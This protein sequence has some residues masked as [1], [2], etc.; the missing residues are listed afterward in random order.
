MK[1]NRIEAFHKML[2]WITIISFS[3]AWGVA[4]AFAEDGATLTGLSISGANSLNEST[5]SSYR[6]V[7]RFSDG[8]TRTVTSNA[9][10]SENSSF[11]TISGGVLQAGSVGSNQTVTITAKYV[12]GGV[13]RTAN[14][15]VTIV[16]VASAASLTGVAVTGPSSVNEGATSNYTATAT[17]S[18]GTTTNV[19]S[20][21]TWSENSTAAT[22]STSGAL[23][24]AQVTANQTVTV[25]ASYTSGTVTR[26]GNLNV[27]IVDSVPANTSKSINSTS[28]NRSTLPAGPVAEQALTTLTNFNI[29][30]VND[31]GMHCG[32]LDHRI[33]SILPPFNVLHAV[34]IQKGTSSLPPEILTSTDVDVIYSAASNPKDPALQRPAAAP[35]FKT[36]FWAPSPTQPKVSIAFDGYDPFYPPLV[37][38]PSALAGDIGL[39]V[40]DVAELYPVSGVSALVAAQQDMPGITAPYTANV[41]QPFARFDTDLPFFASFGFGYRLTNM[42]WFAGDGIPI[43]PFD[44]FGRSNAFP[45]MRVQAKSKNTTL[46]G[47]TGQ[48]FAS[49]DSVLP[50]SAEAACYKCHVSSADGGNGKAACIP[51]VDAGCA[52]QGSPRSGTAFVVARPAQDTATDVS[53]DAKREWAADNNIIRLHDAKHPT[54]LQNS[55]PVVCQTCHYTPALDLAHFGPLGPQQPLGPNDDKANGRDQKVH[56]TNSNVM[57]AFHGKFTDLFVNDLPPPSD[58][59]RKDATGKLVVNAFVEDKLNNSCYQCHPGPNTKC[60]RGAMFNGGMVC[61]DCHGGMQQVGNDFSKNFSASTPF[62]AGAD[63]TK[64]I[65]WANEPKC[66]S[67]HTG[68]AVSNLGLTDANVIKSSD[69]IR[70]LQAW[71]TNDATNATPILAT[72]KRFAEETA[73]GNTVLYRVSKGH[74]GVF[75]EA[76]HGSTHAEWPVLPES[77]ASIANDNMAS[78]QLQGHTGKIIE[79]TTCHA[80]GSLPVGLGGP[81]GMHP[82]G[83]S[84]F[85]SNHKDIV[86][87]QRA[88]CRACHGQT[89][90]GTVLSKVPV[91][92]TVGS[93]SFAKGE[94]VTCT[95]CHSNEL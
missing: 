90:Q 46:T 20:S 85:I 69:G 41:P 28:Q 3:F 51:N 50:V 89:G 8:S 39:P 75:C 56:K 59:R 58:A 86:S 4:A 42:K 23:T 60:L 27:T 22:I 61:N 81:H 91:A 66:Q 38:S 54:H 16:N 19:T 15:S 49:V 35:I 94:Q 79:C 45:L 40:P 12:L 47:A 57:H 76:C 71:R 14:K 13:T 64:R 29:F 25:T 10:W 5:S 68:D 65:P 9:T 7:A 83:D 44:D 67:C 53:S 93:R 62:P 36:N 74:S 21:A 78:I 52:T 84:R 92:R 24:A 70:L 32:D 43:A 55:T 63:L 30:C 48:V 6:A 73:N 34:V 88:N 87:S 26:S 2:L 77:G 72:N 37:L 11:A 18:N 80:A 82:V 31:L 95:K 17:F 33:A 1:P